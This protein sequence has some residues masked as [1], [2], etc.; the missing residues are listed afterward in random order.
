MV[1]LPSH[2]SYAFQ[3]LNVTYFKPLKNAFRKEREFTMA[4]NNYFELNNVTLVKW[5]NK[6]LQSK[7]NKNSRFRV[8]E[9]WPLNLVAML[10][11]FNPIEVFIATKDEVHENAYPSLMQ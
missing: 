3:L 10:G 1:T 8:W 2:T 7:K 11:K 5:V 9:I 6:V 4:K